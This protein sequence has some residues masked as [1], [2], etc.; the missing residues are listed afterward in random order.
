MT[1]FIWVRDN[2]KTMHYINVKHIVRV[3]KVPENR[4][5]SPIG[6]SGYSY[7]VLN[8]GKHISL[9]DDVYDTYDNVI[10]KIQL[11]MA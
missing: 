11:A 1:R 6:M 2:D 4:P 7:I 5:H 8:D 3:T 10:E 9:S